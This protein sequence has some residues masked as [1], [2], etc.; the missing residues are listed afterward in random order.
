MN[1]E[2]T[3]EEDFNFLSKSN[4]E[5][6]MKATKTIYEQTKIIFTIIFCNFSRF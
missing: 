2:N 3:I 4:N 6:A 1:E 5:F